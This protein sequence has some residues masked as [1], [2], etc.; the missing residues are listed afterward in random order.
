[1]SEHSLDPA[2]LFR[3][4]QHTKVNVETFKRALGALLD[5]MEDAAMRPVFR[6]KG[7]P[8][9]VSRIRCRP[10]RGEGGIGVEVSWK[11]PQNLAEQ[12]VQYEILAEMLVAGEEV[13]PEFLGEFTSAR[14]PRVVIL[15]EGGNL[16]RGRAIRVRVV[17]VAKEDETSRG[18]G[19]KQM[20]DL[21]DF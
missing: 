6:S 7:P 17:A 12:T 11:P 20:C 9:R 13:E 15:V 1:M 18:L 21:S 14:E 8:G 19:T 5:K 2:Y 4:N 16:R 3:L 10:V